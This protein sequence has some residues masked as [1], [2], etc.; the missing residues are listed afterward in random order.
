M[1]DRVWLNVACGESRLCDVYFPLRA[2]ATSV[3]VVLVHGGAWIMG[4]KGSMKRLAHILCEKANVICVVPEYRL[5]QLDCISLKNVLIA[6]WVVVGVVCLLASRRD[7]FAVFAIVGVAIVFTVC[8][9]VYM[10]VRADRRATT[11]PAHIQDVS[12][13]VDWVAEQTSPELANRRLVL[14]GHSAGAHLCALLGLHAKYLSEKAAHALCGVICMSGIYSFWRMQSS[15]CRFFVNRG[16]FGN[17]YAGLTQESYATLHAKKQCRCSEHCLP[18]IKQWEKTFDAWPCFQAQ[19]NTTAKRVPFLLTT[20][21]LDFSIIDH[22]RDFADVLHAK[23]FP[24]Q[25]LHFRGMSH[26]SRYHRWEST[27]SKFLQALLDFLKH[28]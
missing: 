23:G 5:S 3:C 25:H 15:L 6:N 16:V 22:T 7:T 2:S 4:H 11:H 17:D 20:V 8:V 18:A 13:C 9:L 14:L 26:F 27:H 28:V 12:G 24:V 19:E 10:L 21:D 1:T